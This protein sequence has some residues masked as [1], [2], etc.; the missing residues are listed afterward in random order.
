[1]VWYS[2]TIRGNQWIYIIV[3]FLANQSKANTFRALL[4]LSDYWLNRCNCFRSDIDD[5][6]REF[7]DSLERGSAN[8]YFHDSRAWLID[9]SIRKVDWSASRVERVLI[10]E[11]ERDVQQE[12]AGNQRLRRDRLLQYEF[13]SKKQ[14]QREFLT[15]KAEYES[16]IPS[17]NQPDNLAE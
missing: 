3:V 17:L 15:G 7:K 11:H 12:S 1:M 13:K 14:T 4:A 5:W 8:N 16:S 10:L 9:A 2:G 6:K